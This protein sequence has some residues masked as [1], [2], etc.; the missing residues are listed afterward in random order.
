M[1]TSGIQADYSF[2][3]IKQF[4]LDI[5]SADRYRNSIAAR[6]TPVLIDVFKFSGPLER[7]SSSEQIHGGEAPDYKDSVLQ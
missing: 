7:C 1:T 4:S 2:A 6:D 3:V 5:A